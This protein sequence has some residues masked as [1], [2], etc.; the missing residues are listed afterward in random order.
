[1]P[2]QSAVRTQLIY[3]AE[4][5]LG[6]LPG[7]SGAQSLRRV[8]SSLGLTKDAFSSN[9][10]RADMQIADVRHGGK[11]V[12]GGVEGELSIQTYD[13]WL[14]A[15]VRSSWVAGVSA[16][17]A[18]F[19]TGVTPSSAGTL[20]FAGAGSLIT[21]GFK[22]GDIVRCT[23]ITGNN[24]RNYRITA[25]TASVMTVFPAPV[26]NAQVAS[27]WTVAVVGS[28]LVPGVLTPSF[29]I[30]H[31][32]A[33]LSVSERFTGCRIGGANISL[34]P[35]G[36][37]TIQWDI[38]GI[39]G[40]TLSGGSYPY[41]TAPTAQTAT[42]VLT[43]IEGGIRLAGVEQGIITGVQM[44]ISQNLSTQPVVGSTIVPDIFYGRLVA[45]GQI[46]AFL[47]D[48][49]LINVFVNESLVDLVVQAN[50][51]GAA[52]QSFLN[53][54]MQNVKFTGYSKTIGAEGGIIVQF[55]FQAL[56][57]AASTT[58]DAATLVIQRSN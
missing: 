22:V 21:K 17:P 8:S 45:T 58:A 26:T 5:A 15:L 36:I 52:P 27:G 53:F 48:E 7:A 19:A 37:G 3:K 32:H 46:S 11:S 31:Q 50:A 10:V 43:G 9:E 14:A 49:S 18:D 51:S 40:A 6:T 34:P 2:I 28:K 54:N 1:M 33:D 23:G 44:N 39:D 57:G 41:F 56:I 30:E 4:T 24:N 16:A 20:S 38:L 42:G 55:P 13:D 25:L 47:Q 35:N 29:T 12:R